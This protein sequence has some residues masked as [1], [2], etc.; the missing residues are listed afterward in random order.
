MIVLDKML[1]GIRDV[2]LDNRKVFC[3]TGPRTKYFERLFY[4]TINCVCNDNFK[5]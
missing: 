4:R 5:L 3:A 1:K 2:R